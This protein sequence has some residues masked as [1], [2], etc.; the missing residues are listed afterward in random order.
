MHGHFTNADA[1]AQAGAYR[2]APD[3]VAISAF[4][5]A[6]FATDFAHQHPD[7]WIEIV[8]I[9][10]DGP[11]SYR[12]YSA[13]DLRPIID[14]VVKMNE[15]GYNCYLG[16]A[17]RHGNKP[18]K[19]RGTKKHFCAARFSWID[20]DK[21]GDYDRVA[22]IC[23]HEQV[24]PAIIV[25][26]GSTP[27]WRGQL[28]FL[29]R[30]PLT[31]PKDV[32]DA[33]TA[34]RD[35]FGSDDVQ[36]CDRILRIGGTISYPNKDKR[37]RGYVIELT[38]VRSDANAPSYSV[39]ALRGLRQSAR[40]H[41]TKSEKDFSAEFGSARGM[42]KVR[43]LLASVSPGHW[44]IPMRDAVAVMVGLGLSDAVIKM[45]CASYCKGGYQ[46]ADLAKLIDTAR[47]KFDKPDFGDTYDSAKDNA[48]SAGADTSGKQARFLTLDQWRDRD[49]PTPDY[50]LG[51]VLSTTSRAI[52]AAPTGLGKSNVAIAI[53]MRMAAGAPFLHWHGRRPANVLYIYG[54]MSRRL[55]KQRLLAEEARLQGEISSRG[56][57][58]FQPSGFHA[59]STEDVPNFQPLNTQIGQSAIERVIVAMGGCDF[60]IFD[61]VMCL[62]SGSMVDEEAWA[63]T[64][65]WVRSLTKRGIGQLWVHHTGHDETKGY[66]TKTREWQMDVAIHLAKV[67]RPDTDVSFKLEFRKARERTPDNRHDFQKVNVFL[68]NDR[69]NGDAQSGSHRPKK[70]LLG[71]QVG[72]VTVDPAA[73]GGFEGL[74]WG[75]G[76]KEAFKDGRGDASDVREALT[77]LMPAPGEDRRGVADIFG[78]VRDQCIEFLA[79]RAAERILLEGEPVLPVDDL[80]Q[81]RE[82]A[83]L[84]CSSE[85]AVQTFIDHCDIAARDLLMPHGDLMIALSVV[86][87]IKRTMNARRSMS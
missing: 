1:R 73:D 54:E 30:E 22:A 56:R 59:L 65:P 48:E 66:G 36:N 87:R 79:G 2:L 74:C 20:C 33:N 84:I 64:L 49:L 71:R 67:E 78:Q 8:C 45:V 46:D 83:I 68:V 7:A 72:G 34:L 86:L 70:V 61:N 53:G 57:E 44:H 76:Y 24:R 77:P 63:Q 13:H 9:E 10:P 55:L 58:Q 85:Q 16:A 3:A 39:E 17:L 75:V 14:C 18:E 4:L 80:R 60:V 26:T 43:E 37:E 51:D 62:I 11:I 5:Y 40:A 81:A 31:N 50:L 12:F 23:Q 27:D 42:D 41:E 32:E 35:L 52:M 15:R 69:W 38:S 21:A 47:E 25:Q 82:L 6:L 28:Y 29:N 19:G